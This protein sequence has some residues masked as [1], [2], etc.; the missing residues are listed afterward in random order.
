MYGVGYYC[1]TGVS[2]VLHL[3]ARFSHWLFISGPFHR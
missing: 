3:V 2:I 1:F